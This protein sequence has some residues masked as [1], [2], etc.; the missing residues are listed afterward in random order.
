[1]LYRIIRNNWHLKFASL[2]LYPRPRLQIVLDV[3]GFSLLNFMLL[4]LQMGR[5]LIGP[6]SNLVLLTNGHLPLAYVVKI[7]AGHFKRRRLLASANN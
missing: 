2:A 5:N 7:T 4:I 3:L 6:Y 1:M